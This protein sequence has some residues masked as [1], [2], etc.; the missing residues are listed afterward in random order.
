MPLE[1]RPPKIVAR[2]GQ[3]KIHYQISGQKQ[4]IT[5]IGCGNATGQAIPPFVIFAAMQVNY[6]W[7]K[8]EVPGTRFGVSDKGWID[9]ELFYQFLTE[10]F[11]ANVVSRR[12]ILLLLDGHSTHFVL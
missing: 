4:Q 10:H 3:K 8:N 11:M 12:P 6:L 9:E 1:P 5:V 7:T 2:K